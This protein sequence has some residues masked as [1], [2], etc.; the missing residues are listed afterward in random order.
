MNLT[1]LGVPRTVRDT[2]WMAD[3]HAVRAL[4]SQL[5]WRC[6]PWPEAGRRRLPAG[7]GPAARCRRRWRARCRSSG[8]RDGHASRRSVATGCRVGGE[9]GRVEDVDRLTDLDQPDPDGIEDQTLVEIA[10][11][12][13]LADGRAGGADVL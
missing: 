2:P 5:R 9:Q 3:A 1:L 12:E 8:A 4:R 10:V 7:V 6:R 11:G 13:V